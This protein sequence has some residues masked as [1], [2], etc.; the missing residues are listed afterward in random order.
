M[1]VEYFEIGRDGDIL[2][3]MRDHIVIDTREQ[4]PL[5]F[6]LPTITKTLC[7]GDYSIEQFEGIIRVERKS[8][9][10]LAACCGKDRCG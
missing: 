6:S 10:D 2:E 8:L 5:K 1:D 3:D 7:T 4:R 9:A